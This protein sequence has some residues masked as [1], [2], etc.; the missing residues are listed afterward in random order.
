[1]ASKPILKLRIGF[2]ILSKKE[3]KRKKELLLEI[4]VWQSG[5]AMPPCIYN[6]NTLNQIREVAV[7][8]WR[9]NYKEWFTKNNI[10]EWQRVYLIT[11]CQ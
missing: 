11:S 9:K 10:K 8:V 4:V 1:M 2:R 3:K 7:L 6:C 5:M